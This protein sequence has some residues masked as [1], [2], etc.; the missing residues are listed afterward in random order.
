MTVHKFSSFQLHLM[1]LRLESPTCDALQTYFPT[2][3]YYQMLLGIFTLVTNFTQ[4]VWMQSKFRCFYVSQL[5][6]SC[7]CNKFWEKDPVTPLTLNKWC[8]ENV[9]FASVFYLYKEL[10][11]RTLEIFSILLYLIFVFLL[12]LIE[13][14]QCYDLENHMIRNVIFLK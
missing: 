12:H 3:C 1:Q 7:P 2:T 13:T 9:L 4:S 11:G 5:L 10:W 6:L 8:I 14:K